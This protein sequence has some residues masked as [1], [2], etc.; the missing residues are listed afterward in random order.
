MWEDP[1]WTIFAV[2]HVV[3]NYRKGRHPVGSDARPRMRLSMRIASVLFEKRHWLAFCLIALLT[4]S[5]FLSGGYSHA[6]PS[7]GTPCAAQ[8]AQPRDE[9]AHGQGTPCD[10]ASPNRADSCVSGFAC[11]SC[12]LLPSD[13]SADFS[14]RAAVAPI[15]LRM[16]VSHD[17]ETP[18]RPPWSAV[19]D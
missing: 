19:T 10:D 2:M 7:G 9:D 17:V 8:S 12:V 13:G 6:F 5:A 18:L 14:R 1:S 3:Q 4:M 16:P 11:G 15:R